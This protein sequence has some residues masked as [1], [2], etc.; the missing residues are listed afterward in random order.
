[1][2]LHAVAPG[3]EGK[4]M[5]SGP[6]VSLPF[7][8]MQTFALVLHELATNAVKHGALR[9]GPGRL[10]ISWVVRDEHAARSVTFHW[11][12]T[13]IVGLQP[14][15]HRG[16]GMELVER[17]SSFTLDTQ[18]KLEFGA[19]SIDCAI[20]IKLP[21]EQEDTVMADAAVPA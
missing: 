2:A 5:I 17:A 3:H 4:T 19:S 6:Q 15:T 12:E 18:A 16:F 13:D 14:P 11:R 8:Q 7:Q 9:P 20:E 10:A 1:M 21:N